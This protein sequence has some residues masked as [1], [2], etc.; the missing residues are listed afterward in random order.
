MK[1]ALMEI[2]S[3]FYSGCKYGINGE[4]KSGKDGGEYEY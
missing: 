3:A 4:V 1:K 2:V